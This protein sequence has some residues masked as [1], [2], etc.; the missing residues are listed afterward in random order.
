[1]AL[2]RSV[3]LLPRFFQHTSESALPLTTLSFDDIRKQFK[4]GTGSV[5]EISSAN[6]FAR[7]FATDAVARQPKAL[8][9]CDRLSMTPTHYI[10]YD[11]KHHKRLPPGTSARDAQYLVMHTG[12]FLYATAARAI[13]IHFLLEFSPAADAVAAGSAEVDISNLEEGRM[14]TVKW[15]GKPV[16]VKHRTEKEIEKMRATPLS[17]LKDPEADD[18]RVIDPKYLVVIGV[19][20]HLG[21]IPI[22][23]AGEYHGW[24][25]PC[26][27]SHYDQSGRIRKGPA[28]YNL[29]VPGYQI[30]DN[31]VL[32]G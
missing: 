10:K 28:P 8:S 4:N 12:R 18:A 31:K 24:Y 5:S 25:C 27:G 21:C 17:E 22:A 6:D 2:R 14:M 32:I 7:S 1:M 30:A 16:F 23:G 13:L 15:R 29:E 26:H 9:P 19:C 3:A 11:E 20:T